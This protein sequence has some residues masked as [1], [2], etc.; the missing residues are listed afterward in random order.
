M[1]VQNVGMNTGIEVEVLLIIAIA[2]F[3]L[4][5]VFELAFEI[6]DKNIGRAIVD[7]GAA[8]LLSTVSSELE[9]YS[10]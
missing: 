3:V 7:V 1:Q 6:S 8:L 4:L 2:A 10:G 5:A 9:I